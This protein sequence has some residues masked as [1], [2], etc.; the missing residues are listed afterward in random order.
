[1]LESFL[2][3]KFTVISHKVKNISSMQRDGVTE[4]FYNKT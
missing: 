2:F 3:E 1:M 4:K